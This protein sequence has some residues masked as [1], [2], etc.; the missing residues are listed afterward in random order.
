MNSPKELFDLWNGYA[1]KSD[2][3]A[4]RGLSL[5]RIVLCQ[6]RLRE[7]PLPEWDAL[8]KQ[9]SESAFLNGKNNSG[10]R[11]SFDW[12]IKN[13]DNALKVLEGKYDAVGK[14]KGNFSATKPS[15]I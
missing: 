15:I 10:W 7:R 8:F 4:A 1:A 13:Q 2:L 14:S 3:I 5:N 9:M 11:A 12:I 6:K